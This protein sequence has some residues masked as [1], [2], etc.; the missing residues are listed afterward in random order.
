MGRSGLFYS[1]CSQKAFGSCEHLSVRFQRTSAGNPN[2]VH[3]QCWPCLQQEAG[4]DGLLKSLPDG[5]ILWF[6]NII[7]IPEQTFWDFL[8]LPTSSY[9][10][11]LSMI[12][13]LFWEKAEVMVGLVSQ[14]WSWS[15]DLHL[16]CGIKQDWSME[17]S[18]GSQLSLLFNF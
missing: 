15:L 10:F 6:R 8:W 14:L 2:L 17:L 3:V 4:L 16:Y 18:T 5:I 13:Y 11:K 7:C 9:L 12:F 1:A